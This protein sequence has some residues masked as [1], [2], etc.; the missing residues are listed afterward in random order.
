MSMVETARPA[1]VGSAQEAM[2]HPLP[3][4]W[5]SF[6]TITP[7]LLLASSRTSISLSMIRV[8]LS[9]YRDVP[10]NGFITRRHLQVM[11][12]NLIRVVRLT[13][14]SPSTYQGG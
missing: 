9:C 13:Y 7:P 12:D 10:R 1:Q 14:K 11:P 2:Q 3:K 6:S 4:A 5:E 8:A